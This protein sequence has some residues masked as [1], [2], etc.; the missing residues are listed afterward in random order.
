MAADTNVEEIRGAAVPAPRILTPLLALADK[1]AIAGAWLA[2]VSLGILVVLIVSEITVAFISK[3]FR[4]LPGDIPIAWEYSGY[5]SGTA[6]LAA[7]AITLR[8]GGHIRVGVLLANVGP[9]IRHA[10]EIFCSAL[11]TVMTVFLAWTLIR[12]AVQA[13]AGD[14][15][16]ID[17]YTPMWIPKGLLA[18]G[19]ILLAVQMIARLI[20]SVA[21][22]PMEDESLKGSGLTE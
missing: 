4:D 18:V 11:G 8:A 3:F 6:F 13:A 14:Q 2:A 15:L 16:S 21:G 9:S 20:R 22:I 17:S 7:T 19:A 12:F 5:L 10:L 1:L